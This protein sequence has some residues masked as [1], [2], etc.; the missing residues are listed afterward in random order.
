MC[1]F[2]NGVETESEVVMVVSSRAVPSKH[3]IQD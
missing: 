3:T 1:K 2:N